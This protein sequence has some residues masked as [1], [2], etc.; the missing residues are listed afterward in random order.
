VTDFDAMLEE[1][2]EPEV[3][4]AVRKSGRVEGILVHAAID[5]TGTSVTVGDYVMSVATAREIAA[6]IT[7]VA[8]SIE[9]AS[10]EMLG[11]QDQP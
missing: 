6:T 5:D 3:L 1:P 8:D 9:Q 10:R 2:V 7:A 11:V 4:F